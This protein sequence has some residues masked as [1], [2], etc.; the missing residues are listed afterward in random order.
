MRRRDIL[1]VGAGGLGSLATVG[2]TST[3][4]VEGGGED[5][6]LPA[7]FDELP[8]VENPTDAQRRVAAI[9]YPPEARPEGGPIPDVHHRHRVD[10]AITVPAWALEATRWRMSHV[11]GSVADSYRGRVEEVLMEYAQ[12]R[13]QFRTPDGRDAVDVILQGDGRKVGGGDG[14]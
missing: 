14:D 7:P 12:A 3:A 6:P 13:E 8:I 1:R 4:A 9:N 5:S 10:V 11:T 2:T